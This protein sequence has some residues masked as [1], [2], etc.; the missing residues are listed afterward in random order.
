MNRNW[1]SAKPM[2]GV[3]PAVLQ[4]NQAVMGRAIPVVPNTREDFRIS[5]AASQYRHNIE[6][7]IDDPVTAFTY[8]VFD[9]FEDDRQLAGVLV[10]T[11]YWKLL[12]ANIL[13]ASASG[14]ICILENSFNESN[15][16]H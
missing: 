12:F 13:P 9:S 16:P 7:Y 11:V 15:L 6:E 1:A 5:L 3:L 4:S 10:T 2:E 8:P 14:I